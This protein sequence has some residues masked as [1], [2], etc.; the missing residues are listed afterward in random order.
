MNIHTI[1]TYTNVGNPIIQL[2]IYGNIGEGLL[3]GES[4]ITGLSK[5]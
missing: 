4:H 2:P 5:F 3:L 1:Y